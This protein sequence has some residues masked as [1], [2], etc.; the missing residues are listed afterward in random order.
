MRKDGPLSQLKP[1]MPPAELNA[2]R[3]AYAG[4]RVILEYGAGGSTM[5]GARMPGKLIISV[6]SDWGW[7]AHVQHQI[8]RAD[9]PSDV[10]LFHGDIGP[11]AAWGMPVDAR[12]WRQFH[13]YALS[14]WDQPFFRQPDLVFVDGRFRTACAV[15]VALRTSR[16][17]TVLFDDYGERPRYASVER[18]LG[19]PVMTGRQ[20][21]FQITPGMLRPDDMPMVIEE[22]FQGR[23]NGEPEAYYEA[24]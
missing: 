5:L 17:V 16:P 13:R 3:R 6:E 23:I 4:A 15:A 7:A 24:V 14:V 20:A 10:I 1:Y 8:D 21:R 22:F 19:R 18:L 2:L 9:C 11:T 12:H